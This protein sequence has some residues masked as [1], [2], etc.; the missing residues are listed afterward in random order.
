MMVYRQKISHIDHSN[1]LLD[2]AKPTAGHV[3][4]S[5][6]SAARKN[7]GCMSRWRVPMLN[8]VWTNSVWRWLLL[9][10]SLH[11]R[12]EYWVKSM[13]FCQI[14]H[15]LTCRDLCKLGKEYL[16]ALTCKYCTFSLD[17]ILKLLHITYLSPINHCK[18]INSQKNSPV[19]WPTLYWVDLA[20]ISCI[21]QGLLIC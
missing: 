10:L 9:F 14:Q 19:F 17:K 1:W 15:N 3:E 2:A 12:V 5:N 21:C 11:V 13:H 8:S 4:P 7:D 20:Y 16:N 18:V 6:Q